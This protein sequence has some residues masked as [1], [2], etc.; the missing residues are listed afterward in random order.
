MIRFASGLEGGC[1]RLNVFLRAVWTPRASEGTPRCCNISSTN[2]ENSSC[3]LCRVEFTTQSGFAMMM[4]MMV[5]VP[6]L[7]FPHI[8]CFRVLHKRDASSS[9]SV[10]PPQPSSTS[11]FSDTATPSLCSVFPTLRSGKQKKINPEKLRNDFEILSILRNL[12]IIGIFTRL[13]KRDKKHKYLK[14]IPYAWKMIDERRKHNARFEELNNFLS[15]YFQ[16]I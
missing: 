11:S 9:S 8:K 5:C 7:L 6:A 13:S 10:P 12:K 2:Y 16:K 15:I 1:M 3:L 4:M 14:L